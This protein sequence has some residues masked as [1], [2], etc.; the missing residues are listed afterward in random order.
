MNWTLQ[1]IELGGAQKSQIMKSPSKVTMPAERLFV[2]SPLIN[3]TE[4]DLF[5]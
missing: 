3:P 5:F 2:R 4:R 1:I